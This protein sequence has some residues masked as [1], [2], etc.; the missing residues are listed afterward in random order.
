MS[1][2]VLILQRQHALWGAEL[3]RYQRRMEKADPERPEDRQIAQQGLDVC[4][5]KM[6]EIA[7][8][9]TI[10][11]SAPLAEVEPETVHE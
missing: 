8:A 9:L 2:A 6:A 5:L 7:A 3:R 10:L 1:E 11:G 4:T